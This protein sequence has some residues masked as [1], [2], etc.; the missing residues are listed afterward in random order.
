MASSQAR[1]VLIAMDGSKHSEYAL[2]YYK[3]NVSKESDDVILVYAAEHGKL[4]SQ[5]V[6]STDPAFLAKMCGEE[7]DEVKK[8]VEKFTKMLTDRGMKGRVLRVSANTPGE[9]VIKTAEEQKVDMV[10]T[11]TRGL[12]KLRRTILG[13]VSQYIVHHAHVPVLIC[14]DH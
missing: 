14:R 13:S 1:K 6:F 4:A 9:A 12:G 10:I 5:P 8:L 2:N 7:E 3:E 11:G